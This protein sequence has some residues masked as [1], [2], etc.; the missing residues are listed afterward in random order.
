MPLWCLAPDCDTRHRMRVRWWSYPNVRTARGASPPQTQRRGGWQLLFSRR[1][2]PHNEL[3]FKRL[4]KQGRMSLVVGLSFLG[5]CLLLIELLLVNLPGALPNFLAQSLTIAGWVAM[6]R[7]IEIYL[8]S[9]WPLRRRGKIFDK[10]SRMP[11]EVR[12][13]A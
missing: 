3:E 5:L 4:M 9:W 12:G 13:R 2:K 1:V 11:V 10:L 8:Y 6:W 7:P